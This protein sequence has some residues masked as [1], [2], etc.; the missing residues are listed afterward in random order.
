MVEIFNPGE[1][2]ARLGASSAE[3]SHYLSGSGSVEFDPLT[4]WRFPNQRGDIPPGGF[5]VVFLDDDPLEGLCELHAGFS[6]AGDGTDVITLWGPQAAGGERPVVDRVWLPP[7][8]AGASFGRF[9]D[10]A[11][12]APVPLEE[13]LDVFRFAPAG[14]SSFGS[15]F[16]PGAPCPGA[17][18]LRVCFGQANGPGGNLAPRAEREA[19][20]SVAPAAGEPVRLTAGVRDDEDPFPGNI[21]LV[22]IRYAVDG[23]EQPPVAMVYDG[24][25][26]RDGSREEPPRPLDQWT[27]WTGAIPGQPSGAQVRFELAVRDQGGLSGASPASPCPPG[28]GPCDDVGL[29]GPGCLREG[30]GGRRFV[31]CD[32]RHEYLVGSAPPEPLA[33]VLMNEVVALQDGII[34]DLSEEPCEG[35]ERGCRFDDYIELVNAS[36]RPA[37]LS[38]LW[39]SDRP[40]HPQGWR[41]PPGSVLEPGGYLIVWAD[42]DGGRCPRPEE[43][44]ED[45]GQECPDPNDDPSNPLAGL[46]HHTSFSLDREGDQVYLLIEEAP[47]RFGVLHAVEFGAQENNVALSLTPDGTRSGTFLPLA[48]GSPGRRNPDGT[49]PRFLRGDADGDCR[50]NLTD[51]TYLLN[52]LF[53]EGRALS[54]PDSADTD[55]SGVLELTDAVV[56]LNY[57]FLQGREPP[58]PGP[59]APGADPTAD[60]LAGC[61]LPGC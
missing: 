4:A 19:H 5:L 49:G 6:L 32:L 52:F 15:C 55:D 30:G 48:G 44:D 36:P 59:V 33:G 41:F 50:L 13:T 25:G 1:S 18:E 38:G 61:A 28:T 2:I 17:Q 53:L 58:P 11:G 40:F 20:S 12:P 31:P 26:L 10:G 22:E 27:L 45:D 42:G 47:G 39:L 29:P 51:A 7:L 16:A 23:V 56:G 21:A 57:L 34:E 60:S 24:G 9:P 35:G 54:C 8:P 43:D 46:E 3:E 37:D 14:M